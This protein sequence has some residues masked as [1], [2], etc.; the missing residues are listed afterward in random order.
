MDSFC[1]PALHRALHTSGLDPRWLSDP[2]RDL[3][4]RLL[5]WVLRDGRRD[6]NGVVVGAF[7]AKAIAGFD[8]RV[9]RH[10]VA[11]RKLLY[12]L[13]ESLPEDA[14]NVDRYVPSDPLPRRS[15]NVPPAPR[16]RPRATTV[17]TVRLP[18]SLW[19]AARYER[20]YGAA[21]PL[22]HAATG[23]EV[24][25]RD[26]RAL[27]DRARG[28]A[29]SRRVSDT[30][31][32][33]AALIDYLHA[34]P[35]RAFSDRVGR[36]LGALVSRAHQEPDDDVRLAALRSIRGLRVQPVPVYTTRP[37]TQ[38]VVPHGEGLA[39]APTWVRR[40]VLDDGVEVDMANA[41]LA[42]VASL[43]DVPLV[44]D[45]LAASVDGGPSWWDAL[46]AWL[47][48]EFPD[49]TFDPVRHTKWLKG[50]LKTLTYGIAFGMEERN[51]ARWRSPYGLGPKEKAD[52]ARDL[53]F[54]R[55]A[56]GAPSKVVGARLL[57]HPLVAAL[58]DARARRFAEVEEAGS[59]ADVFG[60]RY[61]I[62]DVMD[63]RAVTVRSA[64]AAEAQ[65][66]EH[67]LM[68]RVARPFL[69]E[70]ARAEA[71]R[72]DGRRVYPEAEVLLWQS[73]GFTFRA[74]QRGREGRWVRAS[75]DGLRRGCSDLEGL[76]GVPPVETT[77]EVKA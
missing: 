29:R 45:F 27:L 15:P 56:F 46:A 77:L 57:E 24:R 72:E 71:A 73:D 62:G 67:F 52:R 53:R 44:R 23:A 61:R 3:K 68:L 30:P 22:V 76:L 69:D 48:T 8:P 6:L 17:S 55:R 12:R 28:A 18:V 33:T 25:S 59:L 2:D 19:R 50:S 74:R 10:D 60:R 66:A 4:L 14:F 26:R 75:S 47:A 20:E 37:R 31:A 70:A 35:V 63:R 39:T 32:E 9:D 21:D 38:R 13:L 34:R 64:L 54:V 11:P 7:G 1:S 51:V 65:A 49:K 36:V 58:L 41:Q 5:L 42:L 43:W 40:T 16:Q